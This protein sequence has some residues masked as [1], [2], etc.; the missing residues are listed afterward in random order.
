MT[1]KESPAAQKEI[2]RLERQLEEAQTIL[3]TLPIMFWYKDRENRHIKINRPTAKFEGLPVTA[4]EGKTAYELY[5]KEQAEAYH[6]DDLEVI[7]SGEPKLGIVEKHTTS[8]GE[9]MWLETGKVPYRDKEGKIIGAIAFAI[10]ITKQKRTQ[11]FLSKT[12]DT[13]AEMIESEAPHDELRK[14]L[15]KAQAGFEKLTT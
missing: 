11:E 5:P 1:D 3:D 6:R 4:I 15:E 13:L 7:N 12:L 9:L 2:A 8:D 14:Y 10:D